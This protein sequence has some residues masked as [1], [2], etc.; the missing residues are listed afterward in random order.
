MSDALSES[1]AAG[2]LTQAFDT[3][4]LHV[5]LTRGDRMRSSAYDPKA[6]KQTVSLTINSDLYAQAKR[7]GINASQVAEEALG[8]EVARRKAERLREEVRR[9]LEALD[10]YEAKHGSFA[11]MVREHYQPSDDDA[12]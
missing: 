10:A 3:G 5:S 12:P 8:Q 7:F 9:D 2:H 1:G 4:M 11:E 6:A